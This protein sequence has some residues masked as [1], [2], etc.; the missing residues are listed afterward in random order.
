M[1]TETREVKM[2]DENGVLGEPKS[3]DAEQPEN[4]AEACDMLGETGAFSVFLAGLKVKQDNVARNA[5]RSG[6]SQEEV[7]QIVS[8]W[9]PGGQRTSKKAIAV[10]LMTDKA[11]DIASNADLRTKVMGAFM[12]NDFDGIIEMLQ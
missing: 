7:E 11:M 1:L 4:W 12:K 2:A 3:Y 10:Q 5:F 6:K 9:R 8:A